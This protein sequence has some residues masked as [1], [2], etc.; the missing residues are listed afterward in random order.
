MLSVVTQALSLLYYCL[1]VGEDL[2]PP[3]G[4][5]DEGCEWEDQT[6]EGWVPYWG[7]QE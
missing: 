5:V 7:L 4:D 3:S 6:Y 1:C 2:L